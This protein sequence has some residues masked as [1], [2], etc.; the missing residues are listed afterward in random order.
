MVVCNGLGTRRDSRHVSPGD[1]FICTKEVPGN[2]RYVAILLPHVL[3]V[4]SL[5]CRHESLPMN[6]SV[7]SHV[8]PDSHSEPPRAR[9]TLNRLPNF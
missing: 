5:S 8:L 1:I 9:R 4:P 2:L 6:Q 7:A 3:S